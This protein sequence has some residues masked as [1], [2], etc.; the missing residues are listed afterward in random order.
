MSS[1][2]VSV[3]L[4]GLLYGALLA[5]GLTCLAMYRNELTSAATA[6]AAGAREAGRK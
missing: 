5:S 3:V 2:L 1:V 6:P 4:D